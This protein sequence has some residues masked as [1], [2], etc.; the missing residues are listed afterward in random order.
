MGKGIIGTKVGMT[1]LFD[2]ESGRVTPVT[3]I[4][5]GPCPVVAVR[6][7]EV[8][9]YNAVQLAFGPVKEKRLTRPRAG[10]LKAAGRGAAPHAGRVPRRRGLGRRRHGHGRDVPAGRAGQGERHIRAARASPARSSGT[11]SRA[12]PSRTARTTCARRGRSA[13]RRRPRTCTRARRWP[14]RWGRSASPSAGCGWSR[15]TPSETCSWSRAPSPARS[16]EWSKSGA[17]ADGQDR[18]PRADAAA[19]VSRCRRTASARSETTRS[20]TRS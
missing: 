12:A 16:A 14:A 2:P 8:D 7:P 20:S 11:G 19:R 10:H 17:T 18:G 13:H 6:T 3:V 4:E 15:S 1:Q 9:G 5:A